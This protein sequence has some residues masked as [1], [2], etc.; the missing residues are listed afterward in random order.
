[1]KPIIIQPE[2]LVDD[3]DFESAEFSTKFYVK[4]VDKKYAYD[5]IHP[6]MMEFLLRNP[7]LTADIGEEALIFHRDRKLEI[8]ELDPLLNQAQTFIGLIHEHLKGA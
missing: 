3:I 6:R 5:L 2:N 4:N 8:M 7:D 1:M